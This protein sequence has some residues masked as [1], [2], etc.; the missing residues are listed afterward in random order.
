MLLGP[1][2]LGGHGHLL[3]GV[4]DG[5]ILARGAPE[6]RVL[7]LLRHVHLRGIDG[8]RDLVGHGLQLGQH[9]ARV[10]GQPLGGR[11][12]RLGSKADRSA[13]LDDHLGHTRTHAGDQLVELRQTL[14][15]FAVQLAHMQVQH[16]GAG[17]VA[18]H[19]LLDLLVHGHGNVFGEIA[20]QP[21]RRIGGRRD[22][23][24]LLVFGEQ[25]AVEKIHGTLRWVGVR[26][27]VERVCAGPQR[28]MSPTM[29]ARSMR[30]GAG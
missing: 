11:A 14:A 2:G 6:V 24:G 29:P 22:D 1:A 23:Q 19:G 10:V 17:V 18:V 30:R 21:A 27:G 4:E 15:A 28:G 20:G 3:V 9:V 8:H 16:G 7:G 25:V 5:G 13:H 26:G 12:V